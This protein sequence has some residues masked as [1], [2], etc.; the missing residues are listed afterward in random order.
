MTP[1]KQR[2]DDDD[3]NGH[4]VNLRLVLMTTD[5]FVTAQSQS[6]AVT[7]FY[8]LFGRVL[9]LICPYQPTVSTNKLTGTLLSSHE[10]C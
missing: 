10:L 7:C 4:P 5:H 1:C 8:G 6:F 2:D 3:D 9:I